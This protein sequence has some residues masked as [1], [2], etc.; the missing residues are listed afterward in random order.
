MARLDEY[1]FGYR[2]GR[3]DKK[4]LPKLLN[5]LLREGISAT[6]YHSGMIR[7]AEREKKALKAKAAGRLRLTLDEP[8]GIFGFLYGCRHRYGAILAVFVSICIYLFTSMLIWDVRISGNENLSDRY[9]IDALSESGL[10]V[11]TLF[12]RLDK[13]EVEKKVLVENPEI[14]WISVNRRGTVI[15]VELIESDNILSEQEIA[16]LYS[17]LIAERDGVVEEISVK[18][19]VA[20]VRVG[21]VV[22]K[23][24]VLI[25]G[26]VENEAGVSFYRAE[27]SVRARCVTEIESLIHREVGEK[28]QTSRKLACMRVVLFNFSINIFKNYGNRENS[29]DIIEEIRDFALFGRYNLPIR[30]EKSYAVEY[31]EVIRER[32]DD[33]MT[34]LAREELNEKISSALRY[35]DVISLRTSG[36]F[37]DGA[38]RLVSR[39]VYSTEIGKESAI[40]IN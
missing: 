2:Y 26:V 28:K 24:D 32:S 8:L 6:A 12:K 14:A 27:G 15:Y 34:E 23:G 30:I 18:S 37:T 19:G 22:R 13:N 29:C 11:G 9:I 17:N 40:E 10:G 39:V 35:S 5:V 7:V 25:S 16:P 36:G 31:E 3:V 21:D 1:I 4:D 33:E 20:I 38:Y